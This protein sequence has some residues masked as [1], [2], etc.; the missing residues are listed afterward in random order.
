MFW[1]GLNKVQVRIIWLLLEGKEVPVSDAL[2]RD[3]L[4]EWF[5]HEAKANTRE[6]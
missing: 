2:E 4:R 3:K 5:E 6:E 1:P